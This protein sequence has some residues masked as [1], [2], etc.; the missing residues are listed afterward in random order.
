MTLH[1]NNSVIHPFITILT[2][3]YNRASLLPRLFDN[4][5]LYVSR[6]IFIPKSLQR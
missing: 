5:W 4:L 3:A 2:P 1:S 6:K